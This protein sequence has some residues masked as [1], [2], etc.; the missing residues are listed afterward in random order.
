M[1]KDLRQI[2]R[3]LHQLKPI[4]TDVPSC[5]DTLHDIKAVIF[6]I[7]GTLL[8]SGSG[9][10]GTA[11]ES[12]S[13]A[14]FCNALETAGL[15]KESVAGISFEAANLI[16]ARFFELIDETHSRL[17]LEG[18]PHPEVDI[19]EIWRGIIETPEIVSFV[20]AISLINPAVAAASYESIVNPVY[21]MP[22]AAELLKSLRYRGYKLGIV[23]NAQF[24]TPLIFDILFEDGL[25]GFEFEPELCLFSY[26]EKRSKP[27]TALFDKLSGRLAS[28]N[29][30][31]AE[32][33]FVGNDMLKDIM[34]S[35]V[36]GYRTA[37]FSGDKRS[38]RLREND[39][40]CRNIKPDVIVDNLLNLLDYIQEG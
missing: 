15:G 6:D 39:D 23:S 33:V 36:T 3:P 30:A 40:A 16:R 19:I 21:P 1:E 29:I 37:L 32:S 13:A 28:L 17:R 24:Y 4:P 10:V 26:K 7:Y 11:M 8:I 22:G 25:S 20:P 5:G 35:S 34:P 18:Y 14:A 38:L 27:D 12:G 2:L 31:P 9:D